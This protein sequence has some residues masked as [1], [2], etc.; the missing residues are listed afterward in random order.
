MNDVYLI[1]YKKENIISPDRLPFAIKNVWKRVLPYSVSGMFWTK[2]LSQKEIDQLKKLGFT[3]K[4]SE[5]DLID[6]FILYRQIFKKLDFSLIPPVKELTSTGIGIVMEIKNAKNEKVFLKFVEYLKKGISLFNGHVFGGGTLKEGY[7]LAGFVPH[8]NVYLLQ[9]IIHIMKMALEV[10]N[11]RT[12]TIIHLARY[13]EIEYGGKEVLMFDRSFVDY[14]SVLDNLHDFQIAVQ[15][16]LLSLYPAI[17]T[18]IM[19]KPNAISLLGQKFKFIEGVFRTLDVTEAFIDRKQELKTIFDTLRDSFM[20]KRRTLIINGPYGIGKTTLILQALKSEFLIEKKARTYYIGFER[21]YERPLY[22]QKR[23]FEVLSPPEDLGVPPQDP[24]YVNVRLA[25]AVIRQVIN[26]EETQEEEIPPPNRLRLIKLALFKYFE[27]ISH[28]TV[29]V[30]DDIEFMDEI[31]RQIVFELINSDT[32]RDRPVTFVLASRKRVF[33]NLL[34][35]ANIVELGPLPYIEKDISEKVL[36]APTP[37]EIKK[38]VYEIGEGHPFLMEQLVK[39]LLDEGYIVE[40]DG[41]YVFEKKPPAT[42]K[43]QEVIKKR[44]EHL[45]ESVSYILDVATVSGATLPISFY[46]SILEKEKGIVVSPVAG[47]DSV[48][49]E[50]IN[51]LDE[52]FY[53]SR[54]AVFRKMRLHEMLASTKKQLHSKIVEVI[55]ENFKDELESFY[56]ILLYHSSRAE[57]KDKELY[58]LRKLY[59]EARRFYILPDLIKYLKRLSTLDPDNRIAYLKELA[60]AYEYRGEWEK[61]DDLLNELLSYDKS[62]EIAAFVYREKCFIETYKGNFQKAHSLIDM[63]MEYAEK[64]RNV[65]DLAGAILTKGTV[66]W[67][68]GNLEKASEFYEKALRVVEEHDIRNRR[69]VIY[70]NLGFI[71]FVRKDLKAAR[72]WSFK[73]IKPC[74]EEQNF[75]ALSNVYGNIAGLYLKEGNFEEAKKYA[76]YAM[77]ITRQKGFF[78]NEARA[79]LQL[80]EILS[81][82]RDEIDRAMKEGEKALA[83]FREVGDRLGIFKALLTL[84]RIAIKRDEPDQAV[85]HFVHALDEAGKLDNPSLKVEVYLELGRLHK[86][87][88]GIQYLALAYRESQKTSSDMFVKVALELSRKFKKRGRYQEAMRIIKDALYRVNDEDKKQLL[89][90]EEERLKRTY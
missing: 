6:D 46:T 47:K 71:Y 73:A 41:S 78:H 13:R 68:E 22:G 56:P 18:G 66:Y 26:S 33:S 51:R 25:H 17:K 65:E 3:I 20:G 40:K 11:L 82:T 59:E 48:L 37:D 12:K 87:E 9:Q 58:Y 89:K 14:V 54:Y 16:H 77:D 35:N 49:I 81:T 24:M 36:K 28:P 85:A 75:A 84:G 32:G 39:F 2:D 62:P 50:L 83:I 45:S 27:Y 31:S 19:I 21:G 29:I 38:Y 30:L 44:M 15:Q 64:S 4:K 63:S 90:E 88:K 10:Y 70:A 53:I 86:E 67:A 23:L 55:E 80:A 79:H 42:I 1:S 76:L 57:L 34:K 52:I 69:C 8:G 43:A 74:K 7:F 5:A 60:E 61:A 72:D